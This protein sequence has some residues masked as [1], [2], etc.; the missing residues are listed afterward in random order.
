MWCVFV[1]IDFEMSK[2]CDKT[3]RV[4]FNVFPLG[5]E[6]G[7]FREF[8]INT[9]NADTLATYVSSHDIDCIDGLVQDCDNYIANALKL[10]Q[11]CTKQS[12]L[13]KSVHA[14]PKRRIDMPYECRWIIENEN[15]VMFSETI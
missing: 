12:I 15:I 10:S 8:L 7:M 1:D 6:P 13:D 4:G 14:S 3:I 2:V 9:M 11:S 5:L